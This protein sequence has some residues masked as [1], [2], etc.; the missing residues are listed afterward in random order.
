MA[1]NMVTWTLSVSGR[2]IINLCGH[3]NLATLR[4]ITRYQSKVPSLEVSKPS[5]FVAEVSEST[6]S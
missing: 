2:E 6:S 3:L 1:Q 5:Q 4:A